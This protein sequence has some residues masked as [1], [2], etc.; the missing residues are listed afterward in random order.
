MLVEGV[1]SC[2]QPQHSREP[3]CMYLCEVGCERVDEK[4]S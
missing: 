2:V 4:M 3:V 1:S